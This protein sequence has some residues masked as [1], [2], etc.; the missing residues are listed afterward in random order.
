MKMKIG[1]ENAVN[2]DRKKLLLSE[3]Q[4]ESCRRNGFLVLDNFLSQEE[5]SFLQN[6]SQ[7]MYLEQE[8]IEQVDRLLL[9]LKNKVRLMISF[10]NAL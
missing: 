7:Q 8:I 1:K 4:L 5:L 2:F 3:K 6:E 9:L 10:F